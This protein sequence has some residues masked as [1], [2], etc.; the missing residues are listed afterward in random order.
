MDCQECTRLQA[1]AQ[2]RGDANHANV[3]CDPHCAEC[4]RLQSEAQ[5]RGASNSADERC[6]THPRP[7]AGAGEGAGGGAGAGEA[8][9]AVATLTAAITGLAEQQR[10]QNERIEALISGGAGNE[11]VA[12]AGTPSRRLTTNQRIQIFDK[13]DELGYSRGD[14]ELA[15]M[16]ITNAKRM[17]RPMNLVPPDDLINA[18]NYHVFEA[19]HDSVESLRRPETVGKRNHGMRPVIGDA[20]GYGRVD[21]KT[22]EPMWLPPY[23]H[24]RA[25]AYDTADTANYIATQFVR[26]LWEVARTLDTIVGRIRDIPIRDATVRV[27]VDGSLPEMLLVGESTTESATAYATSQVA[28]NRSTLTAKKFTIQSI[29]SGE[30]EEESIITWTPFLRNLMNMSAAQHLGS[31]YYNGDTTGGAT[32]N[33]NLD[34]NTPGATKHYLAW[35]GIRHFWLVDQTGQEDNLGGAITAAAILNAIG[36]LNGSLND[37]DAEVGNINWAQNLRNLLIVC[38]FDTFV[39]MMGLSQAETVDKYGPQATIR[40]GELGS[41]YAVPII[42]PGYA[43]KTEAD[44][45]AADAA[46]SNTKGALT[47]FNPDGWLAGTLR[48]VQLFFD[49][50]QR[51][52]QF[53]FELY[54]RKAF[55]SFNAQNNHTAGIRNI[56]V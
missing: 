48:S 9:S 42:T 16:I 19:P 38:D 14:F 15:M 51:T 36:R 45:K 54:T 47:L 29:W 5:A 32:G 35:D 30:L 23:S 28:D 49:R 12:N 3:R 37:V 2:A 40:S 44:G 17:T 4:L 7:G 22:G 24:E 39:D 10:V 33:I 13:F 50:I 56:T 41:I 8:N 11:G 52:D 31:A 6:T 55:T 21:P 34:D 25:G 43:S 46:A 53:L 26:D 1:E 27:P 18:Y 20:E